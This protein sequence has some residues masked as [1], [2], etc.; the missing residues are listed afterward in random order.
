MRAIAIV[1]GTAVAAVA[2]YALVERRRRRLIAATAT[3]KP[4][5]LVEEAIS[6]ARKP[7]G[8]APE[9]SKDDAAT[10]KTEESASR[11][12]QRVREDNKNIVRAW[13][14]REWEKAAARI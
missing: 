8:L 13:E 6:P 5:E 10:P 11:V 14:T 12:M 7:A 2:I 1:G 9:V 4:V 3:A